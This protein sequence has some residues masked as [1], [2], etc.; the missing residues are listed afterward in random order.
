[1]I[2]ALLIG[3]GKMGK[4]IAELA[5]RYDVAISGIVAPRAVFGEVVEGMDVV[6]KIAN[7]RTT[8]KKGYD[9]V[10]ETTVEILS[11]KRIE[12]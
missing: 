5:P 3:Y 8:S 7:I 11:A 4:L 1:M 12:K 9:D 2:R 6:D 10:P